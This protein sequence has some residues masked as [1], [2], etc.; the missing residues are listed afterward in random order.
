[1]TDTPSTPPQPFGE[2]PT[3]AFIEELR[4]TSIGSI[5]ELLLANRAKIASLLAAF[6]TATAEVERLTDDVN[7]LIETKGKLTASERLWCERAG[8]ADSQNA[9]LRSD[10]AAE[11]DRAAEYAE[12]IEAWYIA[13]LP[14]NGAGEMA[15]ED[16]FTEPTELA[17]ALLR[18]GNPPDGTTARARVKVLE[19]A[20]QALAESIFVA[21]GSGFVY[22][23]P[24]DW[25]RWL[26]TFEDS[27]SLEPSS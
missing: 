17:L 20:N 22:I 19:E 11:R 16:W 25:D 23:A 1:M 24:K 4:Q 3:P 9:E 7:D 6:D 5:A 15:L 18:V 27:A 14:K 13:H 12:A 21:A 26:T 8:R 10:L 2:K